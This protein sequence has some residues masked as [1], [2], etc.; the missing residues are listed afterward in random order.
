M[1]GADLEPGD[2]RSRE[3]W[4][5]GALFEALLG[6]VLE[7]LAR[8][9]AELLW[10]RLQG[11]WY[12]QDHLP[13]GVTRRVYLEAAARQA[14]PARKIGRQVVTRREE[15]H[16]WMD[17]HMIAAREKGAPVADGAADDRDEDKE[18]ERFLQEQR[19]ARR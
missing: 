17:A 12:D 13:V 15:L 7:R 2:P 1:S 9:V 3:R 19:L 8:R 18:Y 16:A 6:L 14:F 4:T 11:E 10:E 5:L